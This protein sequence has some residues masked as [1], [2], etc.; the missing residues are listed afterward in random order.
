MGK[1]DQV[2]FRWKGK[3]VSIVVSPHIGRGRYEYNL[4]Q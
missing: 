2:G 4:A 3:E 1:P